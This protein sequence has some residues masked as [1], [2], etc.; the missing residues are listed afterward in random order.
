MG[1]LTVPPARRSD[2]RL[3]DFVIVG[4]ARAGST[5]LH[6]YLSDHPEVYLPPRKELHYFDN[7]FH[8]GIGWYR[9][10]FR[11]AGHQAVVGEATPSYMFSPRWLDRLASVLP[12]ARL[13]ALLRHPVDRAYSHYWMN[14]GQGREALP[15]TDALNAEAERLRSGGL[16]AR[17]FAYVGGGRYLGQLNEIC[18]RYPRRQ[19]HVVIFDD[20]RADPAS[21]YAELCRFLG[22]DDGFRPA[23]LGRPVNA[24]TAL[25]S[26]AL[27][28]LGRRLPR[29]MAPVR[30]ALA[31]VN[32]RPLL[33]PALDPATRRHLVATFEPEVEALAR[34][35]GRDL[36]AWRS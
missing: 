13:I 28:R 10:Q 29:N 35:L 7:N 21:V 12:D 18:H 27:W 19:L 6:A 3:P 9:S 17:R 15:F 24:P 4:A 33:Y 2:G 5:A 22:V 25:R 36:S 11:Q 32:E 1:P 23:T 8:R 30:R 16:A 26:P 14:R 31:R 20:L 34:W